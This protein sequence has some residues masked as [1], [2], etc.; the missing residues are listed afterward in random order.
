MTEKRILIL[1][2][3]AGFGHRS[4][5]QAIESALTELYGEQ[6]QCKVANPTDSDDSPDLIQKLENEYDEMVLQS[7]LLY[8]L[9]YYTLD[10]PLVSDMVRAVAGKMFHDVMCSLFVDYKPDAV[11]STYPFH[12]RAVASVAEELA[13]D[14][15]MAVVITDLTDVQ[16]LWYS[17]SA[18][19][20][21]VPTPAVREQAYKNGIPATRV[22]VTGIPVNPGIPRETRNPTVLR[23]ALGWRIEQPTCL[24]VASPRT[25]EMVRVTALLERIPELQIAMVCGGNSQLYN[26][27]KERRK[28]SNLHLYNWVDNMPQLMKASDFIVSKAGGLIVSESLACSLPMILAEALPGQE[29]GNVQHVVEN[30]AGAWAPG[31]IEVLTTTINWLK[32]DRKLLKISRENA[33]RLGKPQAAYDIAKNLW[34]LTQ[35]A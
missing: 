4:A 12:A 28:Q 11:V 25:R 3:D 14:C 35:G 6:C 24:I 22:R 1:T 27:L 13:V 9:S 23:K 31:P 10:T 7:P 29:T 34:G 32:N 18:T 21:F 8:E 30:Q 33:S 15:P 5:A 26:E 20:H 17:P 2:S 16:S 19:M